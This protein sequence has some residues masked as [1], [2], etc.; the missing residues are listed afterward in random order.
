M[1]QK[2][3]V[4]LIDD[5]DGQDADETVEFA[6]DGVLYEIDLATEN[7]EA[8][9]EE[10]RIYIENARRE[11]ARKIRA[12]VG[13]AARTS[14]GAHTAATRER[15]QRIRR[16]ANANGIYVSDFGRIPGEAV[17]AFEKNKED[18]ASKPHHR[19]SAG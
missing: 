19:K 3:Y 10:L 9:R 7:A 18:S 17:A 15:N 1:A 12:T 11:A 6:L 8:L 16:W 14:A 13:K 4:E 2:T 5:I